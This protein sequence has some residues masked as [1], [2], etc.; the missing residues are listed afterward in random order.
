MI[1]KQVSELKCYRTGSRKYTHT[2]RKGRLAC[3]H[4]GAHLRAHSSWR[5]LINKTGLL[6]LGRKEIGRLHGELTAD[7]SL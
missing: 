4:S 1:R 3:T 5:P 6:S 7:L 2:H